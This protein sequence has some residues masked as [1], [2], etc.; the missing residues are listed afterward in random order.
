VGTAATALFENGLVVSGSPS[1]LTV[2]LKSGGSAILTTSG[3]SPEAVNTLSNIYDTH[4]YKSKL[5]G[6]SLSAGVDDTATTTQAI[7]L[8]A[9]AGSM[10]T[11]KLFMGSRSDFTEKFTGFMSEFILYNKVDFNN[12]SAD[13]VADAM[14]SFH[15]VY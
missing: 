1:G 8:D 11:V 9:L 15:G 13:E 10:N 5:H 4:I 3:N 14:N 12:E 7:D 6:P 2:G